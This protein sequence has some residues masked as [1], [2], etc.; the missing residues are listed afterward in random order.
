MKLSHLTAAVFV[1]TLLG[2]QEW[3]YRAELNR[4]RAELD[5][6]EDRSADLLR[7]VHDMALRESAAVEVTC[8][9]PDYE[10]GWDDAEYVSGCTPEE[11]DLETLEAMCDEVETFGYIPHC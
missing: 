11:I 5:R 9:C 2:L 8:V 4:D 7:Q 6:L 3:H 10:E 1:V